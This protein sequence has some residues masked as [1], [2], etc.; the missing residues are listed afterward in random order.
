MVQFVPHYGIYSRA[1]CLEKAP[2][3]GPC[4]SA[5]Q[6]PDA[7]T[8][9]LLGLAGSPRPQPLHTCR[10]W[11]KSEPSAW[12]VRASAL[13]ALCP[14]PHPQVWSDGRGPGQGLGGWLGTAHIRVGAART[15][16][17]FICRWT[18]RLFLCLGSWEQC[19]CEHGG[20]MDPF[21]L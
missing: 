4:A 12:Q 10:R 13:R 2:P 9:M 14:C 15:N 7:L 6:L 16:A 8:L 19:C 1:F 11:R 18:L 20:C 5:E 3:Q 21:E 17:L